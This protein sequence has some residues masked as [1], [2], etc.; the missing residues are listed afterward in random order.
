VRKRQQRNPHYLQ[1]H[2]PWDPSEMILR[3]NTTLT[4]VMMTCIQNVP[5]CGRK[6][7]KQSQSSQI[8]SIPSAPSC[9]SKIPSDIW[10]LITVM[11]CID[12]S[13]HKWS[14][15]TSLPWE[16]P[17]DMLSKSSRRFN[18]NHKSLGLGTPHNRSRE[19]V[20]PTSRTKCRENMDNLR[21]TSLSRK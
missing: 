19:R 17:I 5:H 18:N 7:T 11:V 10:F 3:N 4:E 9:V 21:T 13:M 8:S 12:T 1:P 20:A 15:W 16:R 2:S 6:G 14:F